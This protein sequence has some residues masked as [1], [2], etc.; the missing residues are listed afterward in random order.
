MTISL[1]AFYLRLRNSAALLFLFLICEFSP[2]DA[3][4]V[5][6][7][8]NLKHTSNDS[9]V[10][11]EF[12]GSAYRASSFNHVGEED[13]DGI[14]YIGND[15]GLLEFDGTHWQLY[16]KPN[17]SPVAQL[18]I[19]QDK[20]FVYGADDIGYYQRNVLGQMI[21]HSLNGRMDVDK[22]PYVLHIAERGGK[23]FFSTNEGVYKWDGELLTKI[24]LNN[25]YSIWNIRG[26]LLVSV[27]GDDG[28]LAI[29]ENDSLKFVND[30]FHFANDAVY[31]IIQK[32]D[33]E[34][35]MFTSEMGFY[36]LDTGTY[37]A[38]LWDTEATRYFLQDSLYLYN[39]LK[40]RDSLFVG[41]TWEKGIVIF[42]D[43]GRIL[44]KIDQDSGL[45]YN[46]FNDP[47]TD[48]RGNLWLANPRG[49][50]Y[51]K[52]YDQD[53]E[54]SFD[55]MALV[56][57]IRSG[58]STIYV[59]N[60]NHEIKLPENKSKSFSFYFSV[61][62]FVKQD[63]EFSYYL[64][65][66]DSDWSEWLADTRKEYTNL[67]GGKYTF[68]LRARTTDSSAITIHPFEVSV[69]VAIKWFESYITYVIGGL[70]LILLIFGFI[71][72]RTHRLRHANRKL[73]KTVR[74]RTI[75]LSTQ[76]EQL[77][78]ANDELI[79][80]NNELDNFVYRSSHDL[81]APLKS[82][83]GL[84][85]LA[86][87]SEEPD[88]IKEYFRLMNISI[89]KQEEFIKGIMEFSINAKKPLERTFFKV[90]TIIDSIVE[91]LKFYEN[92]HKVELIR[93]Y[94]SDFK[95][96]T[97]PK[98]LNI[99]LRNLITNALKYHDFEKNEQPFIKIIAKVENLSY[100]IEVED[101]GPGI[102][103]EYKEKVFDMFFRAH[104][105][106][107]GSGLGLYIVKDT[108]NVLEGTI[109]ITS[110]SRNGTTFTLRLPLVN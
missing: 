81:V 7:A 55:P 42:D 88:E 67:P 47:M 54:L 78:I 101:N 39:I 61:P 68:H 89:N 83:R 103:E 35:L 17:F 44:H 43:S 50:N 57:Y 62:S 64:E 2:F 11:Y 26:E 48:R 52:W 32:R 18:K 82:L 97:D 107:S 98:R 20:I 15:N 6:N 87:I 19:V 109:E 21:Y 86:N 102:A 13:Q 9:I 94:D 92:A 16:Q 90:D 58:D 71:K 31:N 110:S 70:F 14:L 108:V 96:G 73:E 84:I 41:T 25:T 99:V 4:S 22:M 3:L 23:V 46:L 77:K 36:T 5:Q 69:V 63:L 40:F 75:E 65:G 51:L 100:V 76:K 56:R 85:Y 72:Y 28:G 8:G 74:E 34:W 27:Y 104:Q 53:E 1:S 37:E 105:G 29:L 60:K 49:L 10:F 66:F 59:R 12:D 45:K 80:I 106:V 24:P 33:G 30:D 79:T 95:I 91:D 93:A 38:E